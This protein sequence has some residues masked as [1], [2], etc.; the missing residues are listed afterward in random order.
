MFHLPRVHWILFLIDTAMTNPLHFLGPTHPGVSDF[1]PS[2]VNT[3][4]WVDGPRVVQIKLKLKQMPLSV[5]SLQIWRRSIDGDM[6][7]WRWMKAWFSEDW[8]GLFG[9]HKINTFQVHR[10]FG[11]NFTSFNVPYNGWPWKCAAVGR[12][13]E[14]LFHFPKGITWPL[15]RLNCSTCFCRVP[16]FISPHK[17]LAK[18]THPWFT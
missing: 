7:P 1:H 18:I 5:R 16:N 3:C 13:R 12:F 4:S 14:F 11:L 2:L 8:K 15:Q 9:K 17:S 10:N 6:K